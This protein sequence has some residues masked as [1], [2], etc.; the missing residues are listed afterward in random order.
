MTMVMDDVVGREARHVLQTYRRQP[1]TFV[2]GEGVRLYDAEGR[3]YLRPALGHRRRIARTLAPR[4]GARRR[5][6]GPDADPHVEPLLPPAPGTAGGAS[7]EPIRAAARLL[8]QQRHRG[9]RGVPEVRA[10]LLVHEGRAAPG[11]RGAR[12]VVPRTHVRIAVGHV[13]RALPHAVRAAAAVGEVHPDERRGVV[14]GRRVLQ[15]RRHHRRAGSGRRRHPSAHAGLCRGDH[16]GVFEDGRPV[17]RRRSAERRRPHRL[18]VL[19][20]GARPAPASGV[21]RQGARQRRAN[22]RRAGQPGSRRH[23]LVR[24]SRDDLRRQPAGVPGGAGRSR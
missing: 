16:R 1:V 21:G 20:Q 18:S 5:G 22:R 4:A 11:I 14:E 23:H 9:G 8:L 10:P 2:R 12:R 3:E 6:A 24:R 7:R 17:H 15:N 19:F 13:R